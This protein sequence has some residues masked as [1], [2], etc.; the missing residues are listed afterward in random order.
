MLAHS[1]LIQMPV[2]QVVQQQALLKLSTPIPTNRP[3]N[4][5]QTGNTGN[6]QQVQVLPATVH[7]QGLRAT[8]PATA[9]S[10]VINQGLAQHFSGWISQ[11]STTQ[12]RM[13]TNV[14]FPNSQVQQAQGQARI[15]VY[16][17]QNASQVRPNSSSPQGVVFHYQTSQKNIPPQQS[18]QAQILVP[19]QPPQQPP[20]IVPQ[21]PPQQVVIVHP[22]QPVQPYPPAPIRQIDHSNS[23]VFILPQP[24]Q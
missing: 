24:N 1:E 23:A 15:P 17:Q 18:Q 4:F 7:N 2:Q 19:P 6:I 3:P 20:K 12:A 16:M 9:Q 5:I 21:Q 10:Q 14:M 8:L 13:Q 11:P 22:N